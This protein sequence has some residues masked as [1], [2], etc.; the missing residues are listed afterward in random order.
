MLIHSCGKADQ[1]LLTQTES[2]NDGA[3]ACDVALF[4]VVE[5]CAT[6]TDE[7]G[8]STLR[9]VVFA[10][11]LHVLRQVGDAEAEQCDLT[12]CA[13]RVGCATAELLEEFGLL[14]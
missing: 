5:Q 12:F 7:A 14:S 4:E 3:I 1:R 13:T 8:E 6:L 9:A 2:L 11:L 10:V